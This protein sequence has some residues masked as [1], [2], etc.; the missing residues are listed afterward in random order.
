MAFRLSLNLFKVVCKNVPQPWKVEKVELGQV[1]F[2]SPPHT[3]QVRQHMSHKH[4][5]L[6]SLLGTLNS[7]CEA[8]C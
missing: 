2:V 1:G 3:G 5:V 4:T 6:K 7:S 8:A